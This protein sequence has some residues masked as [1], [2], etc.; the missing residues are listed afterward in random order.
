MLK[1]IPQNLSPELLKVLMEMGHGDELVLADGNF[2]SASHT[3]RLIRLDGQMMPAV[4]ESILKLFPL[5]TFV[6][7][8]VTYM[9][10]PADEGNP[11]IW[12]AYADILTATGNEQMAIEQV[13][14]FEFYR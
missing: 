5:D 7:C 9:A 14:R 4:L 12:A 1:N 2:P 8:P 3:D 10:T 13:D 11:V 6:E